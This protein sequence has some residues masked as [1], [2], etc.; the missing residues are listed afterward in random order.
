M[1]FKILTLDNYHRQALR[2]AGNISSTTCNLGLIGEVGEVTDLVKKFTG[3]GHPFDKEEI[4][5]ELGDVLWYATVRCFLYGYTMKDAFGDFMGLN[6]V[7][8]P[9][10]QENYAVTTTPEELCV[11]MAL[12]AVYSPLNSNITWSLRVVE[13]I[14]ELCNYYEI[15]LTDVA[16]ANIR[17]LNERYPDGFSFE[18]SIARVAK[19]EQLPDDSSG[20]SK[21][22]PRFAREVA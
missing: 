20:D 17:K 19:N 6:F 9:T 1:A 10:M 11:K 22:D 18:A 14:C 15:R 2:T 16:T 13:I 3:Q 7:D 5:K 21:K 8:F 12:F 4:T